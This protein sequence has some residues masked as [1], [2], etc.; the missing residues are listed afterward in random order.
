MFI[1]DSSSMGEAMIRRVHRRQALLGG[2]LVLVLLIVL[3]LVLIR[4]WAHGGKPG[5]NLAH[6]STEQSELP[7]SADTAASDEADGASTGEP[8]ETRTPADPGDQDGEADSTPATETPESQEGT[9]LEEEAPEEP[10][11]QRILFEF[12]DAAGQPVPQWPFRYILHDQDSAR[13]EIHEGRLGAGRV[14]GEGASGI[15]GNFELL[16]GRD[17]EDFRVSAGRIAAGVSSMSLAGRGDAYLAIPSAQMEGKFFF[18]V[19]DERERTIRV[20]LHGSRSVSLSVE[21]ADGRPYSGP[22]DI[23]TPDMSSVRIMELQAGQPLEL[24]LT[25]TPGNLLVRFTVDE[26]GFRARNVWQIPT[27]EVPPHLTLVIPEDPDQATIEI[28]FTGWTANEEVT[29]KIYFRTPHRDPQFERVAIGGRVWRTHAMPPTYTLQTIVAEGE[30]G[31]WHSQ[32][33]Q[34]RRGR[35]YRFVAVPAQPFSVRARLVH[36]DGEPYKQG[37][38][39][40]W[41]RNHPVWAFDWRRAN[42]LGD[43]PTPPEQW[44]VVEI[45]QLPAGEHTLRVEAP[46]SEERRITVNGSPGES[47]D[48]GDIVLRPAQGRV[49]IRLLNRDPESTYEVLF[50]APAS[51]GEFRVRNI[52][53]DEVVVEQVPIRPY[54]IFVRAPDGIGGP[55]PNP[56]LVF[57]G[58]MA[59]LEVDV[60]RLREPQGVAAEDYV[61]SLDSRNEDEPDDQE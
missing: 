12:R 51:R 44:G 31:L 34:F 2:A 32:E 25:S 23:R 11:P 39:S 47:I 3:G 37:W 48:L 35:T 59:V 1:P 10:A 19:G 56:V 5:E 36:A 38:M 27:E 49:V 52:D 61:E 41:K 14:S 42:Q 53:S 58:E 40:S 22:V 55:Q 17:F 54:Q 29:V 13:A 24:P 50:M 33:F 4:P 7:G 16:E 60:S 21:F 6:T 26:E 57:E 30:S 46:G 45:S 43:P 8:A 18:T 15:D 28:D 9:P 20:E